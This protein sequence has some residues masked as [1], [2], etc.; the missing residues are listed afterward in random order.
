MGLDFVE[1]LLHVSPDGGNGAYEAM[2]VILVG[3]AVIA[4]ALFGYF[5]VRSSRRNKPDQK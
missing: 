4:S 1:K 2:I 5:R 3:L